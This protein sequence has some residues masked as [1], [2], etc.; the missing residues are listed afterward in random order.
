M[1]NLRGLTWNYN[2][3]KISCLQCL[4]CFYF[5]F[6]PFPSVKISLTLTLHEI[7]SE[8]SS[9]GQKI[10]V[11]KVVSSLLVTEFLDELADRRRKQ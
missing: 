9:E 2:S 5:D 8:E 11:T 7:C 6:L 4:F 3:V 1:V 10:G